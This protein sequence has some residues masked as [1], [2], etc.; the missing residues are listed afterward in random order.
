MRRRE[1]VAQT[2]AGLTTTLLTGVANAQDAAGPESGVVADNNSIEIPGLGRFSLDPA[3]Y[4][5]E[6]I[7]NL[8]GKDFAGGVALVRKHYEEAVSTLASGDSKK[9]VELADPVV[10]RLTRVSNLPLVG[11]G[12]KD[13]LMDTPEPEEISK[14]SGASGAAEPIYYVNGMFTPLATARE[15]ARHLARRFP[16][17]PVMLFYNEGTAPRQ[18]ARAAGKDVEEAFRDR[19]WPV[20]MAN[21]LRGENLDEGLGWAV[22]STLKGGSP[23]QHNPTTRQVAGLLYQLATKRPTATVALVGYSQGGMIVRNALYT[24]A[25]LGQQTFAENQVAFVAPGLPINSYEVWPLPKKFTPIVD[26][27]DPVPAYLGLHGEGFHTK[28]A[29]LKHHVWFEKGYVSRIELEMLTL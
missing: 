7:A 3:D 17:R 24:L 6:T 25:V 29:G 28:E 19:V 18:D 11:D 4:D 14:G 10:R 8:F 15:E 2:V 5:T 23:L 12:L 1:F 20:Y 27:R 21:T 22:G 26:P 13:A 16:A 9:L